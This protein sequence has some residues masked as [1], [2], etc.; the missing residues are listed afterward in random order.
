MALSTFF[1]SVTSDPLKFNSRGFFTELSKTALAGEDSY[2]PWIRNSD[3]T[4]DDLALNPADFMDVGDGRVSLGMIL[5]AVYEEYVPRIQA[6]QEVAAAG[7]CQ[8][9]EEYIC[10]ADGNP[11]VR[12]TTNCGPNVNL[13]VIQPNE[14]ITFI[15]NL[16]ATAVQ[17]HVNSFVDF[18]RREVSK[19][20]SV[21]LINM[22]TIGIMYIKLSKEGQNNRFYK[23]YYDQINYIAG[24]LGIE[25]YVK[26]GTTPGENEADI[27]ALIECL[28]ADLPDYSKL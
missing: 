3:F 20:W 11:I 21:F 17:N 7:G 26:N 25:P 9:I 6:Y 13:N 2:D 22:S 14:V 16:T 23:Y 28:G 4:L 8:I 5:S 12:S 18:I 1:P 15:Q 19:G 10:D 27:P 24:Q